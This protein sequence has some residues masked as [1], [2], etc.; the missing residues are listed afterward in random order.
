MG[1][2]NF[3]ERSYQVKVVD[4]DDAPG[5]H[6]VLPIMMTRVDHWSLG[7]RDAGQSS[8]LSVVKR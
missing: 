2:E 5:V 8:G 4:S 1:H 6:G 3:N 7:S